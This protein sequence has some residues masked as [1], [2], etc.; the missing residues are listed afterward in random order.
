MLVAYF[1]YTCNL[2]LKKS[3]LSLSGGERESLGKNGLGN[4]ASKNS[5]ADDG[6]SAAELCRI[7]IKRSTKIR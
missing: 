3:I 1:I 5:T 6:V 4:K 7:E 2:S